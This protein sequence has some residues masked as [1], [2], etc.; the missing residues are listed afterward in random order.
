MTRDLLIIVLV[1][2]AV[3]VIAG[4]TGF[5]GNNQSIQAGTRP[6]YA[7][8]N[9]DGFVEP[10]GDPLWDAHYAQE[11]NE[12][13]S[14]AKENL[15]DAALKEAQARNIQSQTNASNFTLWIFGAIVLGVIGFFAYA[16]TR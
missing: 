7:D 3:G 16:M 5:L 14:E 15:G 1:V 10:Q 13:N 11:V 4:V 12:P 6:E 8:Q 2:F 9:A